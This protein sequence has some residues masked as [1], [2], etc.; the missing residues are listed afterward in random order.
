MNIIM[1]EVTDIPDATLEDE[2]VLIG[3]SCDEMISAEDFARWAGTIN[4]EVI[5]RVN[6]RIPRVIV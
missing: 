5:T 6:D 1:V 3:R 4:Y 2:V